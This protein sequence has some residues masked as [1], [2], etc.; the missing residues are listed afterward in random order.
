MTQSI[1]PGSAPVPAPASTSRLAPS[2]SIGGQGLRFLLVGSAGTILQLGLYAV[3]ATFIG[4]QIASVAAWLVSTLVTN[5][6]HRALTFGVHGAER[7]RADQFVAF[8]TCVVGLLIT[9]VVL[10]ELPD[11][12][13]I[14]GV[15]AILAVNVTVGGA[16]FAGLRWWLGAARQRFSSRW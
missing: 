16:R 2:G 10:A 7:N 14:S 12:D 15:I 1:L 3:G 4:V 6:A 11:A 5:A 8:L 9:S 13:G